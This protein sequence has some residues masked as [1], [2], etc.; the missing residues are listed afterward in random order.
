LGSLSIKW[1]LLGMSLATNI[2]TLTLVCGSLLA[3]E[4]LSARRSTAE[5]LSGIAALI[6]ARVVTAGAANEVERAEDAL[7]ALEMHPDVSSAALYDEDGRP[8]ADYPRGSTHGA[9]LS[10][11]QERDADSRLRGEVVVS[12]RVG[13]ESQ[14][15]GTLLIRSDV[16]RLDSRVHGFIGLL[17]CT[18]GISLILAVWLTSRFQRAFARPIFHLLDAEAAVSKR[19]DYSV[20]AIKVHDDEIGRLADAFNHMVAQFARHGDEMVFAKERAEDASRAKSAF[21]AS[22]SHELRTPLNA[23][24]GYSELLEEEIKERTSTSLVEDLGKITTSGRHLLGLINEVLDLSK[25]E[26]GKMMLHL[27]TVDLLSVVRDVAS[28]IRPLLPKKANELEIHA[29]RGLGTAWS[30]AT[31]M[32]QILSNLL[33]NA[34]KFTDGGRI[35]LV[36]KRRQTEDGEWIDFEVSD[37]GIGIS[38]E[39]MKH[40]FQPFSQVQALRSGQQGTSGLGLALCKRFCLL[41][42]GDIVV[43]SEVGEG[44]SFR[45]TLPY[46]A[47]GIPVRGKRG[48]QLDQHASTLTGAGRAVSGTTP[49]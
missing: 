11:D 32:R 44:S 5:Q 30:D 26:A 4:L 47:S 6:E 46:R 28:E 39:Q 2:A 13:L 21:L 23:I 17:A 36:A 25:V 24:I 41:L 10:L 8:V 48:G 20:R 40:L 9:L 33:S 1:K 31:R 18:S 27:E 15:M 37:T 43:S 38:P 22:M 45:V 12:R 16:R 29:E 19:R 49:G 35:V 34:H 42:G 14:G 7:E 3:Y